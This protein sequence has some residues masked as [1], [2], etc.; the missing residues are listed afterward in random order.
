MNDPRE[1]LQLHRI[2]EKSNLMR[3]ATNAYVFQVKRKA[4]KPEIKK[5]VEK[6][7]GVKVDS[8]RTMVM[9]GKPKRLG[10]FMGRTTAWKKAV[11][12]LAQGQHITD[13]DNV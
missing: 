3:E 4:T 10:R 5:A 12:T 9:P 11:V 6:A 7:F 8:V 1:L 13:F 2:T